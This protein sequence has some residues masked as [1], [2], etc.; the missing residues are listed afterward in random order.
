MQNSVDL[1]AQTALDYTHSLQVFGIRPGLERVSAVCRALGDPHNDLKII[2]V[3]GTNGKG[4]VCA[5]LAAALQQAGY[6]VGLYTSP[7]ITSFYERIRL[8]GQDISPEDYAAAANRVKQTAQHIGVTLT[9]FEFITAAAF[10]YYQQQAPDF[11]VLEVGMGG[12]FDATNVVQHPAL[13]VITSVSLDHTAYLGDTVEQIA[14][15]K[16]GILKQGCPCVLAGDNPDAV[17]RVVAQRAQ[18]LGV[19]LAVCQ[20]PQEITCTANGTQFK[21]AGEQY[22]AALLGLHQANNAAAAV[23]ALQQLGLE[24]AEICEGL[25]AAQNPARLEVLRQEPLVLLDGGH[26]EAGGALLAQSLQQLFP[27]TQFHMLIGMMRDKDIDGYLR[28]L[29]PLCRQADCVAPQN[30]RSM[31]AEELAQTLQRLGVAAQAVPLQESTLQS[32]CAQET[33]L[34][35]CG[36]LYLAGEVRG[37]LLRLLKK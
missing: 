6:R 11:V 7:Y 2:H 9:E 13:T 18:E 15:E 17:R 3:A 34:L 4:S 25:C 24:Y 10:V 29:I 35:I 5:Y 31:P 21:L 27:D 33:P 30:P 12:R 16:A 36:S 19:P 20:P 23:T 22:T 28:H 1:T 32:L 26:N 8:N 14:F 37:Q